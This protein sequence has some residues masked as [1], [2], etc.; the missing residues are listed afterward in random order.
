[1]IPKSSSPPTPPPSSD[2]ARLSAGTARTTPT[3]SGSDPDEFSVLCMHDFKAADPDQL[4]FRK[5]EILVIVKRENTGWWAAM[6]R[7][8]DVIGWI[9]QAFVSPLTEEMAERLANVR[10]EL[11]FYEYRAEQLYSTP[12]SRNEN[13]F[14][15]EPEPEPTPRRKV[16]PQNI[17]SPERTV[18]GQPSRPGIHHNSASLD[19]NKPRK[20]APP[21]PTT[22]MPQPALRVGTG[23][24]RPTPPTPNENNEVPPDPSVFTRKNSTRRRIDIRG[25]ASPDP[26]GTFDIALRS[27]PRTA[28]K[29]KQLPSEDYSSQ[30]V[31]VLQASIPR[32]L[33]PRYADQLVVDPEGQVRAGTI[34]ALIEKLLGISGENKP[35][36]D[37]FLM[38]FRSFMSP[39]ALFDS[40][41]GYYNLPRP[42]NLTNNEVED[43][44]ERAQAKTQRKVLEVFSDWL[45]L[46]HLLEQEPNI[47]G[48]LT[49]FLKTITTG[50][51]SKVA[52]L[53]QERINVL[54]FSIGSPITVSPSTAARKKKYHSKPQKGD[55]LKI[56]AV[57][58]AEQLTVLLF[59]V[60]RK[61]LPHECIMYLRSRGDDSVAN[62][63][64]FCASHD[65]VVSWVQTSI[66]NVDTMKKR[67]E[68]VDYWIKVAEKCRTMNNIASMSAII[69]A[70]NSTVIQRLPL[71]MAHVSRKS[72]LESLSRYNDPSG[73][74]GTYRKLNNVEGPCLPF[75]TMYLTDLAHIQDQYSDKDGQICF[76]KRKR[77]YDV[78]STML[79]HQK[80][81]YALPLDDVAVFIKDR[82]QQEPPNERGLW[83]KSEEVQHSELAH[84]DIRRGLEKAGF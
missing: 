41:V 5:N 53:I 62:L 7:G 10:E 44:M 13:V 33:K 35:F 84:A 63:R 46:N 58:I 16:S 73:S 9:P 57:D 75:I 66:L 15:S 31:L 18:Q 19:A 51:N 23:V 60:Y 26:I 76:L 24:N 39:D 47:A 71:T 22:P 4:S 74:F 80:E 54:T 82:L 29:R 42:D 65:K 55:L 34:P 77:F 50:P 11:R 30:P 79:R 56:E 64:E 68:T 32:Y 1:M 83:K 20:Y 28:D 43:W 67:A 37:A 2:S 21:S 25:H 17:R 40:L 78:I 38:T 6:R 27:R 48:R 59:D 36:Q 69:T 61:I 3:S 12:V 70:L 52:N 45:Q 49:E 72:T 81:L 8:G 14:E